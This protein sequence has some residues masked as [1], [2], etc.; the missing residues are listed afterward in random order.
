MTGQ[1]E[2]KELGYFIRKDELGYIW[3]NPAEGSEGDIYHLTAEQAIADCIVYVDSI[4]VV[5]AEEFDDTYDP[6]GDDDDDEHSIE[7]DDAEDD[8]R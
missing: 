5:D 4:G 6:I 7:D 3:A 2:L 8:D 1:S